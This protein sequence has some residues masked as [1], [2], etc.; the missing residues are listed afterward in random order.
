MKR[1][2]LILVILTILVLAGCSSTCI[3]DSTINE[4]HSIASEPMISKHLSIASIEQE[5]KLIRINIDLV[6]DPE[7]ISNMEDAFLQA[8]VWSRATAESA[9]NILAKNNIQSNVSVWARLPFNKDK[10][11]LLGNTR[12]DCDSNSYKFTRQ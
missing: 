12:Y 3:S 11:A 5:S 2:F 9:I 6:Y 10:I 7:Y 8:E 1:S 4:L